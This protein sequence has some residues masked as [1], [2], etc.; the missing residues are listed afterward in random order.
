MAIV[1]DEQLKVVTKQIVFGFVRQVQY[2]LP[3]DTNPYYNIPTSIVLII[4]AFIN[5]YYDNSGKHQW[6]ITDKELVDQILNS[7]CGDKFESDAFSMCRLKWKLEL[8]PFGDDINVN[9]QY[10]VICLR[11]LSFIPMINKVEFSRIFT[12]SEC[13]AGAG[14]CSSIASGE[15]SKW[16]RKLPSAQITE[17]NPNTITIVCSI[18]IY[19]L[20]L[21]KDIINNTNYSPFTIIDKITK[22]VTTVL[23][24]KFNDTVASQ[25]NDVIDMWKD[26]IMY[27]F[28]YKNEIAEFI[29]FDSEFDTEKKEAVRNAFCA[30]ASKYEIPKIYHLRYDLNKENMIVFKNSKPDKT[31]CSDVLKDMWIIQCTPNGDGKDFWGKVSIFLLLYKLPFGVKALTTEFTVGCVELDKK[32]TLKHV[33]DLNNFGWGASEFC[34]LQEMKQFDAVMFVIEIKVTH[35]EYNN[36]DMVN[37]INDPIQITK[38][39]TQ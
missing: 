31:M 8:F 29:M 6:K 10:F 25:V 19:Q 21:Q 12:V 1:L 11:L 38:L 14:W 27:I 20:V 7:K 34:T 37:E 3:N 28:E 35:V 39:L 32:Y 9:N 33:F 24:N 17:M 4:V 13:N 2:L 26:N 5:N 30:I 15:I 18:N 22:D 36:G 23:S 16:S